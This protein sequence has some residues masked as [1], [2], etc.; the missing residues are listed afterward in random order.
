[1][2]YHVVW[3]GFLR[4]IIPPTFSS[5]FLQEGHSPCAVRKGQLGFT[6]WK[7]F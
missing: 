6:A 1:M 4:A 7:K 2:K 5:L 3:P